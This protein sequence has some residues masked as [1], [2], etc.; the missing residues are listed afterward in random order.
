MKKIKVILT[1]TFG[2]LFSQFMHAGTEKFDNSMQDI[3]KPYLVLQK[4]L[5]NDKMDGIVTAAGKIKEL[6][7]K[8]DPKSV[9]G[10]HAGH[11]KD[12]PSNL[13]KHSSD[14]QKVKTIEQAREEFKKLSKPM[15]MWASMSKPKGIDV[16]Y[17][18]MAKASWLQPKG[19]IA[20]PYYGKKMSK[21]GSVIE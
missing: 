21:C 3:L 4:N 18:E 7:S 17:C 15:A 6:S 1:I 14:L 11:Y 16:M 9:T 13:I 12:V 5:S 19:R 10:E 20:N 2:I 8:L